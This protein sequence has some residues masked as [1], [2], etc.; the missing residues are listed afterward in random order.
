MAETNSPFSSELSLAENTVSR[1]TPGLE[2]SCEE[3]LTSNPIHAFFQLEPRL[4]EDDWVRFAKLDGTFLQSVLSQ[5]QHRP[6]TL[7]PLRTY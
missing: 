1:R 7:G 5:F 2:I 4:E 3:T 6:L